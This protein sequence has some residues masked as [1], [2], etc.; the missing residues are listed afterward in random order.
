M[1]MIHLKMSQFHRLRKLRIESGVFN[2]ESY[3]YLLNRNHVKSKN[4]KRMV[5]KYL[6]CCEN[7]KIMSTKIYTVEMLHKSD[8]YQEIEELVFPE[9]GV[10]IE[11]QMSGFALELIKNHINVGKILNDNDISLRARLYYVIQLG[12]IIDKVRNVKNQKVKMQFGD[13]NEYN[14]VL[15]KDDKI[16]IIDL[17]SAY[18]GQDEFFHSSYYLANNQS[19]K[20]FDQKYQKN[21]RGIYIPSDNTDMYCYNMIALDALAKEDMFR[22]SLPT[23]YMYLHHLKDVGIDKEL[24]KIF[25][26]V[27]LPKDNENPVELLKEIDIT[28]EEDMSFKTF[29]KEY[30]KFLKL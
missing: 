14:A 22:Y 16:R 26:S 15:D 13:F 8:A 24:V 25:E 4:G 17:D 21:K 23:Y 11:E 2:S 10:S 30:Q 3:M 7:P 27:Y 9:M 19:L 1:E 29:R 6:D 5:F 12:M 28:K 20:S 18:V